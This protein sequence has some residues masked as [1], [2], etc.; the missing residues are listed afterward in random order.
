MEKN[1]LQVNDEIKTAIKEKKPV[2]ALESTLISHGLPHP[3]N[4]EVA[5]EAESQLRALG[6]TPATV[7]IINGVLQVGIDGKQIELIGS[8]TEVSK[9]SINNIGKV[10]ST[11]SL[12]ATTVASTMFAAHKAG[13]K[14][15]ATGGI[16][17]VHRGSHIDISADL[18]A[19]ST[20]PVAVIC[21]G[22]K[23]ILDI[24][25][26]LEV[27]ETLGVPVIGY[28]TEIFP[29]FWTRGRDLKLAITS[30][31]AKRTAEILS[32]HWGIGLN[33]GQLVAVPIPKE[34][35]LDQALV[36]KAIIE[37]ISIAESKE[38]NGSD[39]TPF[40]LKKVSEVSNGL[41]LSANIDLI[42]NN[43]KVA[44]EI[45]KELAALN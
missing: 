10:L 18:K 35:A 20:I 41:T 30:N 29:E 33:T 13:I 6:V 40:L 39:L 1:Y 45:S 15:F 44:G 25:K 14:T 36:E 9:V 38:I 42:I 3:L 19:L 2:V 8:D 17:G 11:Q 24:P 22:V 7:A 37:S 32:I 27:L 34:K 4:V 5:L 28:K 43:V 12:G 23:A 31:S 21:A 16:G 26:T